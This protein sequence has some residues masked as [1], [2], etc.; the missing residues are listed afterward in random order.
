MP[1]R[2]HLNDPEPFGFV[3]CDCNKIHAPKRLTRKDKG[4]ESR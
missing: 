3:T 1:K 2:P 4:N